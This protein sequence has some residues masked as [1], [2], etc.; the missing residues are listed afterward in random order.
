M[1]LA[2]V[3]TFVNP[4]HYATGAL[5]TFVYALTGSAAY[6]LSIPI[7]Y[8]AIGIHADFAAATN[9]GAAFGIVTDVARTK[10]SVYN[11]AAVETTLPFALTAI[12]FAKKSGYE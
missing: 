3:V 9:V 8:E 11:G 10:V 5:S 4:I 7:G 6:T 12:V 1:V 2:Q